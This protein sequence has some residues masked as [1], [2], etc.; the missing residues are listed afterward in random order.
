MKIPKYRRSRT[1]HLERPKKKVDP[2][3]PRPREMEQFPTNKI[4]GFRERIEAKFPP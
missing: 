1:K 3:A 4:E 2:D